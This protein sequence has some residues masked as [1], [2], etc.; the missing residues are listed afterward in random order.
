MSIVTRFAPSPTGDL[1]LGHAFAAAFAHRLARQAGGRFLVRIEDIDRSRCRD[2]YIDRN[3]NDLRWLG[4]DWD[5]PI[6]RQSQRLDTYREAL[7]QLG[8]LGVTYPCFCSRRQVAAEIAAAAAAP[9]A[10]S[11]SGG[12]AYPG[13]CRGIDQNAVQTR[14]AGGEPYAVRLDAA[15][16][17]GRAGPVH[18]TDLG[19]GRHAVDMAAFGDVVVARRDVAASYHLA[20][21]TDDAAQGVTHVTRGMDLLAATNIHRLLYALLGLD[22]PVWHHHP[23]CRDGEGRRLAKRDRASSIRGL[24]AQGLSASAVLA[25][26]DAAAGQPISAG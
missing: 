1:H 5:G 11:A 10:E 25:L 16:A 20:V 14:I 6:L 4:L 15:A 12:A 19:R 8:C 26:A 9:H 2:E 17:L 21:V 22:A 18:W 24:R 23:V 3:L 13:T 7:G